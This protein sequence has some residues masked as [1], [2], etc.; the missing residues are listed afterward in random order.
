MFSACLAVQSYRFLVSIAC[1][2][3]GIL[4]KGID[5]LV[6]LHFVDHRALYLSGDGYETIV[7]TYYDNIVVGKTDITRQFSVQDIVVDVD[8]CYQLVMSVYL[9]VSQCTQIVGSA[10]HV[11][12][13]EYGGEG[14]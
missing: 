3:T 1:K 10:S 8:N 4:Q 13:M 11:E 7:W 6:L 14:R 9:D 2:T 5:A 12:G